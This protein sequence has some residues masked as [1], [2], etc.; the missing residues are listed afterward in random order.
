MFV[1]CRRQTDNDN[2]DEVLT[3]KCV[4]LTVVHVDGWC[5]LS[6]GWRQHARIQWGIVWHIKS[7]A[8]SPWQRIRTHTNMVSVVAYCFLHATFSLFAKHCSKG[9]ENYQIEWFPQH[10]GETFRSYIVELTLD[11]M[12]L[13]VRRVRNA[14]I[15]TFKIINSN[16]TIS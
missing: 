3:W 7:M 11:T 10:F 12:W 6:P 5:N 13:D 2:K 1:D 9:Y 16:Y 14:V 4:A 15:E 8:G